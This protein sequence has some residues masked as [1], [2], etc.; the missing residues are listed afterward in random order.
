MKNI[1]LRVNKMV[2]E[3]FDK[4]IIEIDMK[5]EVVYGTMKSIEEATS[6]NIT[7]EEIRGFILDEIVDWDL[8]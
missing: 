5:E 3:I 4:L 2:D 7:D 1:K 6:I 8:I